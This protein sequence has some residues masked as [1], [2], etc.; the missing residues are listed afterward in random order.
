MTDTLKNILI[1]LIIV[2][3]LFAA[4]KLLVSKKEEPKTSLTTS[5]TVGVESRDTFTTM[6]AAST[7]QKIKSIEIDTSLFSGEVFKSLKDFRVE[8]LPVPVGRDNPFAP[9]N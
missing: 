5:S 1:G 3:V 4:Y 2:V 9:V 6:E 7:L 8:V